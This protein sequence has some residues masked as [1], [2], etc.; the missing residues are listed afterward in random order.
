MFCH[1][2]D[3]IENSAAYLMNHLMK[4]VMLM[5]HP[6]FEKVLYIH[7]ECNEFVRRICD[8]PIH[9]YD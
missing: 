1:F 2:K 7:D 9:L 8:V 3:V 6:M 5:V 4:D